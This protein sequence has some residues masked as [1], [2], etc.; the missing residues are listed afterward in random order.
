MKLVAP[1]HRGIFSKKCYFLFLLNSGNKKT[2]IG[3]FSCHSRFFS[4]LYDLNLSY[5]IDNS[6]LVYDLLSLSDRIGNIVCKFDAEVIETK[7]L[8]LGRRGIQY[9]YSLSKK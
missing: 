3:V 9:E 2:R 7:P 8:A 5:Y 1:W 4:F 6:N